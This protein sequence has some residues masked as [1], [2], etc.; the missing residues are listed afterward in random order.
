MHLLKGFRIALKGLM[1]H[2]LRAALA[3]LGIVVG[4]A[5]VIVMLAVG[6]GAK[7][8]I[9]AKIQGLGSNLVIV[10]AGQMKSVAGR[11]Q[12]VG[13]VTTLDLRDVRAIAE[14]CSAIS[15]VV[16]IHSRKQ[17][18][19]SGTGTTNTSVVGTSAEFPALREFG[20]VTGRFFDAD[21][22]QGASRV[23]VVGQTVLTNL[24]AGR[25]IVGETIRIGNVPFDVIGVLEPKGVN[26]AGV[27]E[28]DQI[29]IPVT[30]ALRRLFN[31]THLTSL[32]V[33]ARDERVIEAAAAQ[34]GA[35]LR[36][37]HRIRTG[38]PDDFTIQTQAEILE[39]AQETSGTFTLLLGSVAGISLFVGGI[40]ILAMMV[41]SVRERTKEI[42]VRRAVG[43][44]RRDILAQFI[45]EAASLSLA[46]GLIGVV[47]GV[48]GGVAIGRVTG[49]PTAVSPLAVLL[50]VGISAVVGVFFG[51]YPAQ[52][53]AHLDPIVALRAE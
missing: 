1:A 36:E 31:A 14:E 52:R 30:T 11:P 5:A 39:A 21:E 6:E 33:Q 4:V 19:K 20:T 7:R 49:W 28:D 8:E 40:G 26:Y 23:A 43:A 34:V 51:A 53:A 41:I 50:A 46:G 48:G 12:F 45:L 17:A 9:L 15:R 25:G 47:V 10:S 44:R 3:T 29:L 38:R 32:Y 42:G 27:D 13:N 22:A 2:K 18:V 35:L 16:P 37:R 24:G